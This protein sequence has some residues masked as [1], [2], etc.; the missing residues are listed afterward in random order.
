MFKVFLEDLLEWYRVV[1]IIVGSF[2]II[3]F[4]KYWMKN[5]KVIFYLFII[6]MFLVVGYYYSDFY[7]LGVLMFMKVENYG[8][9]YERLFSELYFMVYRFISLML[10][11]FL[12][13]DCFFIVWRIVMFLIL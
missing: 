8:W 3:F 10:I 13:G 2:N 4:K 1:L 11:F 5:I 7:I 6:S 12:F 9:R